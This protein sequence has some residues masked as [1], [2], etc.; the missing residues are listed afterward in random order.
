MPGL[1]GGAG[2]GH[3]VTFQRVRAAAAR[4]AAPGARGAGQPR[5][6][7]AGQRVGVVGGADPQRRVELARLGQLGRGNASSGASR[8]RPPE[9]PRPGR[10]ARRAAAARRSRA[11]I[12]RCSASSSGAASVVEATRPAGRAG[13]RGSSRRAA[14]A[15]PSTFITA[16]ACSG[17][18]SARCAR[19]CS[20][21]QRRSSAV[22]K[23]KRAEQLLLAGERLGARRSSS[24]RP[25]ARTGT[26]PRAATRPRGGGA[27]PPR[28]RTARGSSAS[29][30]RAAPARRARRGTRLS[31]APDAL[32]AA[33]FFAIAG[34]VACRAVRKPTDSASS[35]A[36]SGC[37]PASGGC[38]CRSTWPGVPALQRL[39][40]AAGDGVVLV[41]TGMHEPRL[42]GATSS[43]RSTRSA[44]RR[45]H[46]AG[47]LHARARRP[48][49]AGA[50]DRRARGLRGLDAPALAACTREDPADID[51]DDRDRAPE[52]R[53]GG[54]APAL[55]RARRGAGTRPGGHAAR[56]PR[57][58]PR[59][60][61][62]DRRRAPGR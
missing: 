50:D 13:R 34:T 15:K 42:D 4:A 48:L 61:D 12:S 53:A 21:I 45:A 47:R 2:V 56:R 55:G 24:A 52:R 28:R 49:R 3:S 25:A 58:G 31:G 59:R 62:R 43:A 22:A 5:R 14:G 40:A 33:A 16:P 57:P 1:L 8:A 30:R 36:A 29:S 60:D 19:S 54:A 17:K 51:R 20:R 39:G 27:P 7:D 44:T 32:T 38:G 11:R 6:V 37:C 23:R 10:A 9:R 46:P 41:D 35:A 18:C 26:R